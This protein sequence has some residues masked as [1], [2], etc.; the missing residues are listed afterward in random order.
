MKPFVPIVV[1]ALSGRRDSNSSKWI[2]TTT[3]FGQWIMSGTGRRVCRDR[4]RKWETNTEVR[5]SW[6]PSHFTS[7]A[8]SLR[9]VSLVVC[10]PPS[11]RHMSSSVLGRV[12]LHLV[13]VCTIALPTNADIWA[14]IQTMQLPVQQ[15]KTRHLRSMRRLLQ[16][17][18]RVLYREAPNRQT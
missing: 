1:V 2:R 14:V 11:Q 12:K 10:C 16:L 7:F 9:S 17:A 4:I 5:R 6:L 18:S 3:H 15:S 13:C 8:F